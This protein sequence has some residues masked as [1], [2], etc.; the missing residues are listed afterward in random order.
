MSQNLQLQ[1]GT[2]PKLTHIR[3]RRRLLT[4]NARLASRHPAYTNFLT[5]EA[6]RA[7]A[8]PLR[9]ASLAVAVGGTGYSIGDKFS[10]TGGT[11]TVTA[12]GMVS[13]VSA[14]VVTG[15]IVFDAGQYTVA[16][17]LASATTIVQAKNGTTPGTGL[18]VDANALTGAV[19]GVTD[20]ELLAGLR[21]VTDLAGTVPTITRARH[22]R[23]D[24][25]TDDTYTENGVPVV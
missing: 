16:P 7:N 25:N 23:N 20:A 1:K 12:I 15:V 13:A 3:H 21:G 5:R 17:G 2:N 22:F 6:T 8:T 19:A 18:T 4:T 11:G 14:G 10:V 24:R 9:L